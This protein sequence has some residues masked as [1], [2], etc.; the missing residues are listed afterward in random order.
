ML[1]KELDSDMLDKKKRFNQAYIDFAKTLKRSYRYEHVFNDHLFDK[2]C[3]GIEDNTNIDISNHIAI[4]LSEKLNSR[5]EILNEI[6]NLIKVVNEDPNKISNETI[7]RYI[8]TLFSKYVFIELLL[9]NN[10]S[11][12]PRYSTLG[13]LENLKI[14]I[15]S[16]Y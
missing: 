3:N 9:H 10:N 13:E 8:V 11:L 5:N 6:T 16:L 12:D 15:E 1:G 14:K 2:N 7:D 4:S